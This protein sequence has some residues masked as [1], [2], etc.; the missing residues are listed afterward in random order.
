LELGKEIEGDTKMENSNGKQRTKIT[1]SRKI[2]LKDLAKNSLFSHAISGQDDVYNS[3]LS[4]ILSVA[5][6]LASVG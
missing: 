2:T 3:I 4:Q 1:I 5:S 6:V